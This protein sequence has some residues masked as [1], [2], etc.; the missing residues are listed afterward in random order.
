AF[1]LKEWAHEQRMVMEPN[2]HWAG[3]KAKLTKLVVN[4]I[5]DDAAA[6]AAYRANELDV[7]TVP[8]ALRREVATPGSSLNKEFVHLPALSTYAFF[9]NNAS[10]PFDNMKLRQAIGMSVD[11]NAYVEGV[12]QGAGVPTTSWIPPGMPGYEAAL[13]R[14]Y[15][16]SPA[17]AKQALSEAG[18]ADGKNLPKISVLAIA[19]DTNRIVGQFIEDQ[20]KRNL[21]IE[22]ETEYVDPRTFG[23]RFTS[24]QYQMTIQRW[25]ADWPYPDNWLPQLFGTGAG[26][27]LTSYSNVKFDDLIKKAKAEVDEK[28]RLALYSQAHKQVLDD[29]AIVPLYNPEVY[30]L[31]KP[32]VKGLVITAL[33]GGIKGDYNLQKAYIAAAAN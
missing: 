4:F 15:E 23:Q 3:E 18:Y 32:N 6:Y 9:F 33:D 1:V 5:A 16:F 7:V 21:G 20:L 19:N 27:N 29:A 12:L 31:V 10:A 25:N 11:R 22:V 26:N 8:P 17:K 2:P 14:Q 24:K 30:V 13:G 28:A